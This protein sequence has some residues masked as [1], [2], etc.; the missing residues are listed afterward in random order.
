[1]GTI[2]VAGSL[3][4]MQLASVSSTANCTWQ[5]SKG[6]AVALGP[7]AISPLSTT[8]TNPLVGSTGVTTP[9]TSGTTVTGSV[10]S[11][12]QTPLAVSIIPAITQLNPASSFVG[13]IL[14]V[15]ITGQFTHF[16]QSTTKVAFPGGAGIDVE[17]ITVNSPTS[18][19]ASVSVRQSTSW[20]S[21]A[22]Q[23]D[24]L[25]TTGSES[26]RAPAAFSVVWQQLPVPVMLSPNSGQQGQTVTIT[27][28]G[29]ST[30]F[31][32]GVTVGSFPTAQAIQLVPIGGVTVSSPT[33]ATMR[34]TIS[35][36]TTWLGNVQLGLVTPKGIAEEHAF[37]TFTILPGPDSYG[38][39]QYQATYVGLQPGAMKALDGQLASQTGEDWFEVDPTGSTFVISLQNV[40]APS[41][42]SADVISEATGMRV[43]SV[44]SQTST[45]ARVSPSTAADFY[46]VRVRAATW[47]VTKPKYTITLTPQ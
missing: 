39:F 17:S 36:T 29:S 34:F 47:D 3:L 5:F 37:G 46:Y 10:T 41:Q 35:P 8:K 7:A 16:D 4:P 28:T 27:V 20:P 13:H 9:A 18:V 24:V 25:V 38:H 43:A 26:V 40:V 22:S 44:G 32:Q 30:N 31:V 12:P 2:V 6:R 21:P 33:S 19:T 42:F 11:L 1:M 23:V 45:T 14:P 15:T